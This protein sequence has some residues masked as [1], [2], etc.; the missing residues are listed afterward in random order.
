MFGRYLRKRRFVSRHKQ[1]AGFKVDLKLTV[2]SFA[3][4]VFCRR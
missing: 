1:E 4:D 2:K 3:G